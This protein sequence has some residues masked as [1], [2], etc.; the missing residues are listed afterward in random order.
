[1]LI[2]NYISKF[3]DIILCA[4]SIKLK[5]NIFD[6]IMPIIT[7]CNNYGQVYLLFVL[8]SIYRN[9]FSIW[10]MPI[11]LSLLLEVTI[12]EILI[13]PL[14]KRTRPRVAANNLL[15]NKPPSYSFPSG[16]TASSF[17]VAGALWS[18]NSN[19]KYIILLMA[20]FISFSRV[21]LSVHYPSDI[22][23]GMILGLLVSKF[24]VIFYDQHILIDFLIIFF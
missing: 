4:V 6:I 12:C 2:K 15:I 9:E 24:V 10:G 1:M 7:W 11:I 17:A 8:I 23:A 5:N 16:H 21:Y 19:Y 3:D 14:I 13:K 22:L 20:I 18:I